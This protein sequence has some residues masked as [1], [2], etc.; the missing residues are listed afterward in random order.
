[1]PKLDNPSA[2]EVKK[3]NAVDSSAEILSSSYNERR[4]DAVHSF[5][6]E[7]TCALT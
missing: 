4:I 7:N 3:S 6:I 2:I 1:M 5:N